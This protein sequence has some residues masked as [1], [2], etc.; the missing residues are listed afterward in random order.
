MS[1]QKSTNKSEETNQEQEDTT[2][3]DPVDKTDIDSLINEI[4]DVLEDNAEKFVKNYVQRGG[5]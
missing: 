4:D 5:E 3:N 1:N 2:T